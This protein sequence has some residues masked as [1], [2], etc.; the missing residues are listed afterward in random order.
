[1]EYR[2]VSVIMDENGY[3]IEE[4]ESVKITLDDGCVLV[5]VLDDFFT[6]DNTIDINCEYFTLNIGVHRITSIT[7]E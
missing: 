3:I 5:G 1:M 2:T 7:K 6:G 4:G